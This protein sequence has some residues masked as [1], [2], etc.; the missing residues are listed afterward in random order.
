MAKVGVSVLSAD[1]SKVKEWL[2]QLE[3]A[4]PEMIQ[5]DVMDNKYVPNSGVPIEEIKKLRP[6]TKLFFDV[7]LMVQQPEKYF[8]QLKGY[9]ADSLTFHVE[10][11]NNPKKT[12][13]EI[14]GLGLGAGIAVNN[15]ISA[16]KI[17]PF[18]SK[19]DLALVMTVEAGFGGQNF[20][21]KNLSKV[22]LLRE[23]IDKEGLNC[24]IQ[25]DGGI[26]AETGKKSVEAGADILIAGSYV[27]KSGDIPKRVQTLKNL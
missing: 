24:E 15:K 22:K 11:S 26:N 8:N 7:H 1:F 20:I 5:W 6:K 17:S 27:I 14:R 19:V 25:V 4:K 18:L 21:E 3:K 16:E 9:G 2:P 13:K 23:A 12:I 10:T